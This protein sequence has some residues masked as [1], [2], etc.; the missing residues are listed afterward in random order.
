MSHFRF[1]T[2]PIM[3]DLSGDIALI[4]AEDLSH[5]LV[6]IK[7][8]DTSNEDSLVD[9]Q[10]VSVDDTSVIQEDASNDGPTVE[11]QDI[12]SKVE[13][14]S[15]EDDSIKPQVTSNGSPSVTKARYP[16]DGRTRK[17]KT[18][19][20]ND[21]RRNMLGRVFV[22]ETAS[23]RSTQDFRRTRRLQPHGT[24]LCSALWV[25]MSRKRERVECRICSRW[26]CSYQRHLSLDD[27]HGCR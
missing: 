23:T 13:D 9:I 24:R 22:Q 19:P 11:K 12:S 20:S 8:Q 1:D 26:V 21:P 7:I 6:S 10:L 27:S 2:S 4:K 14:T 3:E 17:E 16:D 25:A 18:T 5:H 15:V